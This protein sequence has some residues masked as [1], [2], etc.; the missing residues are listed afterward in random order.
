MQGT[1]KCIGDRVASWVCGSMV[2]RAS[3]FDLLENDGFVKKV[4]LE[5]YVKEDKKCTLDQTLKPEK[6]VNG[7]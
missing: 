7:S 2:E 1:V 3:D 4:T 6:D 5:L